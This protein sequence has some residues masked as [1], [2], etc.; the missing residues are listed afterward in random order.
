MPEIFVG[1][2]G[3]G[4]IK[5][6]SQV[7][8]GLACQCTCLVCNGPLVAR[9][10][11]INE[12][13]FAHAGGQ[14]HV[15]CIVG[16]RNFLRKIAAEV[17]CQAPSMV[18]VKANQRKV[19]FAHLSQTILLND[20]IRD[21]VVKSF[22]LDAK[23]GM[24]TIVAT[25]T[26]AHENIPFNLH[27]QVEGEEV[28]VL[29][30]HEKGL[31]LLHVP[32]PATDV[33]RSEEETRKAIAS[34]MTL[35]WQ[36]LPNS[37]AIAIHTLKSL[38]ARYQI[39]KAAQAERMRLQTERQQQEAARIADHQGAP[40]AQQSRAKPVEMT[41]MKESGASFTA[42]NP[43][44]VSPAEWVSHYDDNTS[45]FCHR[46]RDGSYWLLG[47]TSEGWLLHPWP[48]SEDGWDEALPTSLGVPDEEL[49]GYFCGSNF[50][51]A[52]LRI[53]AFSI[54]VQNTRDPS[55]LNRMF[56]ILGWQ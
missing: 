39:E 40:H 34:T 22:P 23:V 11:Q 35:E 2:G 1:R 10:G 53:N 37:H 49:G 13:H 38:E 7:P 17:L 21:L 44:V 14:T 56:R 41:A 48:V 46:F 36:Y 15:D 50:L 30:E 24:A 32:Y 9:K 18:R 8:S 45:L 6:L 47:K 54:G 27:V 55:E 19:S 28:S 16:A 5:Y 20:E 42:L 12:W 3:D 33:L 26:S 29:S 43:A 25:G 4:Q 52:N 31:L 51:E